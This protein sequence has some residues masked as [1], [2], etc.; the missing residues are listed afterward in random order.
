[1]KIENNKQ[2][3]LKSRNKNRVNSNNKYLEKEIHLESTHD[4]IQKKVSKKHNDIFDTLI[5]I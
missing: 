4:S 5:D 2:T 3:P 1:M